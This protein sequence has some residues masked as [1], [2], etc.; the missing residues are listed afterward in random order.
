MLLLLRNMDTFHEYRPGEI[1]TIDEIVSHM[2]LT[3]INSE[4]HFR[5][6]FSYNINEQWILIEH[7]DVN[8]RTGHSKKSMPYPT[9]MR[10]NNFKD[11]CRML[12][13][14]PC[15][16]VLSIYWTVVPLPMHTIYTP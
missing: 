6:A 16:L 7:I 2:A 10:S 1:Y 3:T 11:D 9:V 14:L 4:G 13:V 15:K 5:S 8:V 12:D